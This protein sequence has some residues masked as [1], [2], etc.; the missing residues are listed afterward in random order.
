MS[1]EKPAFVW[2]DPFLLDDQLSEEERM[3]RDMTRRATTFILCGIF[4]AVYPW[5]LIAQVVFS[6]TIAITVGLFAH[7]L[8][9]GVR[10]RESTRL[11]SSH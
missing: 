8:I 3:I 10:D 1:D 7:D 9:R 2:D 4:L 6:L 5:H 11:N